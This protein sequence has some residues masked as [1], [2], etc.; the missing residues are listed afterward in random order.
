LLPVVQSHGYQIEIEDLRTPRDFNFDAV[1]EEYLSHLTWPEGHRAE[2]QPIKLRD[3]QVS[4]INDCLNNLQ[5]LSIAPTAGGKTIVSA[6]LSMKAEKYGRSIVIVPNVNLVQQTEEDYRNLGLD[7]GVLYGNRKEYDRTHTICTWQSLSILDK[8]NKDHLDDDQLDIFL[9][10]LVCVMTDECHQVKDANVVHTLLTTTFANIP[11]RWGLTGTLPE[12]EYKQYSLISAIGPVIGVLTARELQEAGH[13]ANCDITIY[14]TQE[15]EKHGNYQAELKF[16]VTDEKRLNWLVSKINDISKTGNTVI[17]VD[18]IPTGQALEAL[19]PGSI[20]VS[21]SMKAD[22]RREHYKEINIEENRVLI[23]TYG[24]LS[25]GISI[26]RIF[27]LVLL[28]AGKSFT[29][30]IQSI[31]RG[32]RKADDKDHVRISDISSVCKFSKRHMLKRKDF[33]K[34]AKYPFKIEKVIY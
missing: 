31:G 8:K 14:Q 10:G 24:C 21:G 18:R 7:V 9:D 32:L 23:A 11:I 2:G 20:F 15:V 19:I 22:K 12:E 34:K 5:G 25:T 13:I 30:V 17:L 3:Y 6:V 4:L 1:D 33:Y 29:R 16:L 28:E 27:N 26:N